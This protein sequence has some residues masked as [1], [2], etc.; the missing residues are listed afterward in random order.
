M[1]E[2]TYAEH[3]IGIAHHDKVPT[4]V[5]PAHTNPNPNS[6]PILTGGLALTAGLLGAQQRDA[7]PQ[8]GRGAELR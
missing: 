6:P 1:D 5:Q 4:C 3:G 2:K 7:E 8:H